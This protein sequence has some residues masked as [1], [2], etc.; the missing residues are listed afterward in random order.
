MEIEELLIDLYEKKN[1]PFIDE[2]LSDIVSKSSISGIT[3]LHSACGYG[4]Y[5]LVETYLIQT[6]DSNSECI[7]SDLANITPLHFCAGI[8]PDPLTPN[9]A[10][11]IEL[12]LKNDADLNWRTSR[13]DT[14]LH[15]SAKLCTIDVCNELIRLGCDLNAV[16]N[17]GET[18]AH[19]AAFYKHFV[20]LQT[21]IHKGIDT[22][23]RD[24]S[25]RTIL[26]ILCKESVEKAEIDFV[27]MKNIIQELIEKHGLDVNLRDNLGFTPIMYACEYGNCDLIEILIGLNGDININDEKGVTCMLLA[28]VNGFKNV[29]ELLLKHNFDL[30]SSFCSYLIDAAYLNEL[31]IVRIL[32]KAG[33]DVNNTKYDVNS[34]V[35]NALWAACEKSNVEI[36]KVL[37]ENGASVI[38]NQEEGLTALHCVCMSQFECL[39]LVYL[40]VEFNNPL[41]LK[42]KNG[43]TPLF[44]ACSSGHTQIVE[45]LLKHKVNPNECSSN[46]ISCFRQAIIKTHKD[47]VKLLI[48]YNYKP[49]KEDL[50]EIDLFIINLIHDEDNKMIKYLLDN[51][52]TAKENVLKLLNEYN[53]DL[54]INAI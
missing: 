9:R 8:G 10:K 42:T 29:V 53:F 45:Y 41:N 3:K 17:D 2:V 22:S 38:I 14:P 52:F 25:G 43:E 5:E 23:I 28:I 33:C 51:N 7:I 19:C 26:H 18:S 35:L 37:L 20:L 27:K 11:C 40:L 13:G 16:N 48:D 21:L 1:F 39:E 44:L 46:C 50:N 34:S 6:I 49:I 30:R 36:A 4:F 15:W 24:C 47:I 32:I 54:D 31:D 12:L